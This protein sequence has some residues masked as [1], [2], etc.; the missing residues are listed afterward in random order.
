MKAV[1]DTNILV[2]ALWKPTGNAY[3]LLSKI[4]SGQIK[5]CYDFRIIKE[6]RD[7]LIVTQNI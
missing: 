6:Y 3:F 5:P 2:S 7:V 4:I 1:I